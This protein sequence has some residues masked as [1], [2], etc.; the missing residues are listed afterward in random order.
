MSHL[1]DSSRQ[2]DVFAFS[3]HHYDAASGQATLSYEIDGRELV[4]TITFPWA[5]WPTDASRQAAFFRALELLH[6]IAGVSYYKAVLAAALDL[7]QCRVEPQVADFLTT[8]YGQGLAEFAYVNQLDISQLIRFESNSDRQVTGFDLNLPER[9]LVAMGG[10]KDSLVC[11]EL[12]RNA[13]V[14][15]QPVCV[16]GAPL[17]GDTAKA[18]GLP[19]IRIGRQMAPQLSEMNAEG[20][21]N[22]HVPVTAINSAILL[23]AAILYGYSYVVF[24][25]EASADEATLTDADGNEVNHQFSKSLAFEQA[26]RQVIQQRVSADIEYFSLLR[27]YSEVAITSRFA[28]MTRYHPVFSSCNRNFHLDG[29][30]IEGR[31]CGQCPKCRFAALALAPFLTPRQLIDIQGSDLL[32]SK[33][34][35]DGFRELCGLDSDKPFECVGSIAE[36]R[37]AMKVLAGMRDWS[38]K[39]V[40]AAFSGLPE[41]QQAVELDLEPDYAS[42]HC[43]PGRILSRLRVL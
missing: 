43:I 6:L 10:G 2:A 40:V 19:L 32:N 21:W 26:F 24:A 39:A 20:A 28:E 14:E 34:Q 38:G 31:W 27:P 4:E 13:G 23:C 25:N 15:V 8:L 7:S 30:R 11:L 22:G 5:P 3:A 16:G 33:D 37:S 18:A 42:P 12:L 1:P 9:A 41:I 35:V 36:S 17:I 29:S